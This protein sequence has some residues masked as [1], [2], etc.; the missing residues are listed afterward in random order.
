MTRRARNRLVAA[1][2]TLV[3]LVALEQAFERL[4]ALALVRAPNAR[5]TLPPPE[6]GERRIPVGPPPATL[7]VRVLEPRL[8]PQLFYNLLV[9]ARKPL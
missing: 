1:V 2:I 3:C 4:G 6:P 9:S 7:S 5:R 8:P